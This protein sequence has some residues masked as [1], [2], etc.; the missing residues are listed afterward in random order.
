MDKIRDFMRDK[1]V[2]LVLLACV[3]GC[4]G[5]GVWAVRTVHDQLQQQGTEEIGG[6]ED[7]PGVDGELGGD[8]EWTVQ[9]GLD[10]AGNVS[11]VPKPT[12]APSPAAKPSASPSPS[13]SGSASSGGS[14]QPAAS[15]APQ[16]PAYTSPVSGRM[17]QAYSGDELV[18]N[19]TLGDWRT[20]NGADYLCAAGESVF[21]PAAGTVTKTTAAGNWGGVVEITAADGMVWR[22]CGVSGIT[23]K[24]GDKLNTGNQIGTAGTVDAESLLGDHIHLEIEK[25][26]TYHN[27]ADYLN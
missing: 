25:D 13:G 22:V 6:V 8:D 15:A 18:Y 12:A 21:A 27:P 7:Y 5:V 16:T 17:V 3:A 23:V 19:Q 24:P 11:G 1:A 20:H 4:V 9:P 14:A 26:G 10:V 2:L